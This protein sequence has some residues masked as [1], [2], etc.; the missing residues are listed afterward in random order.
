[1]KRN[2]IIAL[3]AFLAMSFTFINTGEVKE[4]D[5]VL[6]VWTS[7]SG[8]ARVKISKLGKKFYGKIIWLKEP[9]DPDT[10]KP[11]LDK[12]NPNEKLRS[13]PTKGLKMFK[14]FKYAGDGLWNKGTIYDP[15]EGKTYSCKITMK[16]INTLDIRGFVGI[17]LLGKTTVWTRYKKKKK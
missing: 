5:R 14:D 6:G 8:L 11:K 9:I 16:D 17:S 3:T 12:R 1:M 2:I 15:K 10:G 4:E 7:E 13:V